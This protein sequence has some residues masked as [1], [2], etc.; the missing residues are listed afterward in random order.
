[1]KENHSRVASVL[2]IN[3][4]A[5]CCWTYSSTTAAAMS[6]AMYALACVSVLSEEMSGGVK[7]T[8]PPNFVFFLIDVPTLP[9]NPGTSCWMLT[10]A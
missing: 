1:V 2:D 7:P 3:K 5:S 9:Q 10:F 6:C 4:A 8:P